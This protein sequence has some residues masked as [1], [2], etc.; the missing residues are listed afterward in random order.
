MVTDAR[1]AAYPARRARPT[2]PR[3]SSA[4]RILFVLALLTVGL[5]MLYTSVALLTRVTPAL[6]PGKDVGDIP[7][8]GNGLD[9]VRGVTQVEKPGADSIVN[10]RI[11]LLILGSDE[12]PN[13]ASAQLADDQRYMGT[14][15]DTIMVATIDPLAKTMSFLGF[16]RDMVIDI[17]PAAGRPYGDRI[18]ASFGVGL[19]E[20]KTVEAGA[21]QLMK[22]MKANFGIDIDYYAMVDFKGVE[23]LV[24]AL[25]GL[26]VNIPGDLA[27]FNWYYSDDDRNAR[28][29]SFPPGEQHLNGYNAVAFGRNREPSD[30]SRIL[31]QQIVLK[32]A[33]AKVFDKGMLDP[34]AWPGLWDTYSSSMRT[35]VPKSKMPGYAALLKET[36]GRATTYSLGDPVNGKET[37]WGGMLGDASVLFWDAENVQYTLNQAF[38]KAAYSAAVVE[39]QNGYG[40]NGNAQTATLGRWFV[41][42]KGLQIVNYGPDR[43]VQPGPTLIIYDKAKQDIADDIATWLNIPPS[44]IQV[45][46]SQTGEGVPDIIVVIGQDY[47]VPGT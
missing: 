22:D 23:T 43:P 33:I 40:P 14:H 28:Y 37:V 18:N 42:A 31:R 25:D 24:D 10:K 20:G 47:R 38:T 34:T 12:R 29:V 39:I 46:E 16:P 27:V 45:D 26:D 3:V 44:A 5:A 9:A 13:P 35:N 19:A 8:F 32:A 7:V 1:R 15:T 30:T 6:F 17:N 41:Y 21:K 11:N 2:T 4:Q 36:N